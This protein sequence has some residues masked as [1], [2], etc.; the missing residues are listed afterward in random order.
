VE[1]IVTPEVD[2][3][4]SGCY[5]ILNEEGTASLC[6]AINEESQ[7]AASIAAEL[8]RDAADRRGLSPC[9]RCSYIADQRA[10]ATHVAEE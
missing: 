4:G 9:G 6:G 7:F 5:H 10:E 2:Q 1:V 8:S 3:R